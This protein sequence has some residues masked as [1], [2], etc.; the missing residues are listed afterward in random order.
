MIRL[1]NLTSVL[2]C[3]LTD[4]LLERV[5][6]DV[7]MT[8]R[9]RGKSY[10]AYTYYPGRGVVVDSNSTPV[11]VRMV[12]A[13]C[14]CYMDGDMVFVE[15]MLKETCLEPNLDVQLYFLNGQADFNFENI[16]LE[17]Y[18]TFVDVNENKRSILNEDEW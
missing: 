16:A 12:G 13:A 14:V 2:R 15:K 9:Y 18:P 5:W 3:E 1:K 7:T 8:P 4:Q 10:D 17:S 11:P 6:K